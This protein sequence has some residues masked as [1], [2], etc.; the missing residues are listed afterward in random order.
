MLRKELAVSGASACCGLGRRRRGDQ[1]GAFDFERADIPR[2]HANLTS[3]T[4]GS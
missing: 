2:S 1:P 4:P 3:A